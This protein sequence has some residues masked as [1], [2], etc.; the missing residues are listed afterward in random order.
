M[1][2]LILL[3]PF[4]CARFI[5]PALADPGTLG[6]AARFAPMYG[7]ERWAYWAYQLTTA[8]M[9]LCLPAL[10]VT[11]AWTWTLAAG[12]A[13]YAA[14]TALCAA[15]CLSFA[16][17]DGLCTGGVYRFS[18][19]PMYV[20]YPLCFAGM[21]LLTRSAA[22]MA[23]TLAFQISA[24]WIVRAEERECARRFGDSYA[25]YAAAARRWL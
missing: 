1:N 23:L 2:G 22:L 4:T 14:G 5:V 9:I 13:C 10:R 12:L 24:R 15:A 3:L 20:A 18:R 17:C 21:A 19:N 6:R 11:L 7:R 16:R 25:R 8:A